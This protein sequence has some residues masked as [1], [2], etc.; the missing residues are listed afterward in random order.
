MSPT[1]EVGR[2]PIEH[3]VDRLAGVEPSAPGSRR[4]NEETTGDIAGRA[5]SQYATVIESLT[6]LIS[7]D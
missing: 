5:Y 4:L 3:L 1:R 7:N 2:Q 6:R